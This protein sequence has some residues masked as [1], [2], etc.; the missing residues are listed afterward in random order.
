M[1]VKKGTH[2]DLSIKI[3]LNEGRELIK[4]VNWPDGELK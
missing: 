1:V 3:K 2:N 4:M